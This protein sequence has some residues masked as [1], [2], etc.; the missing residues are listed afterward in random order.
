MNSDALI[1]N[2]CHACLR[3][4]VVEEFVRYCR[5]VTK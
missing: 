2:V 3:K 1:Q 5:S 4:I